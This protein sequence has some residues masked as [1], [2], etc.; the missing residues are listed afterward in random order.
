[1]LQFQDLRG[2]MSQSRIRSLVSLTVVASLAAYSGSR[3]ANLTAKGGS[4][5]V[6]AQM[7]S[8]NRAASL[9]AQ[10]PVV[11]EPN[12]GQTDP[13][14]TYLSRVG[15]TR[16]FLTR[17][18]AVFAVRNEPKQPASIVRMRTVNSGRALDEGAER[19]PGVSNYLIGRDSKKWVTDVPQYSR[20]HRKGVYQGIDMV[21]YGNQRQFE[22]DFVVAPGADAGQIAL[23]FD[24]VDSI[25]TNANGDLVLA[26]AQGDL[27]QKRPKVYQERN[28]VRSEVAASYKVGKGNQVQFALARYDRSQALVIDPVIVFNAE[29]GSS[30]NDRVYGIAVDTS[31]NTYVVGFAPS[32]DYPMVNAYQT[33]YSGTAKIVVS[34]LNAAGTALVYSTYI[35]GEQDDSGIGIAVDASGNALIAGI[36]DS[37]QFPTVSAAQGVYGGGLADGVLVKLNAAGSALLYST[38]LGGTGADQPQAVGVDASGNAYITGFTT[39]SFPTSAGAFQATFMGGSTDCTLSKYSSAGAR[40]YATYIGGSNNDACEAVAADSSGN[41]YVTGYTLSNDFPRTNGSAQ[42]TLQGSQD[43]FV[44]K[45]NPT[46]TAAVYST[47]FGGN[48]AEYG[49][50]IAIDSSGNAYIT[51]S[52]NSSD[53]PISAGTV[54][55][56]LGGFQNGF[57]AKLNAAG[58]GFL[59]V[60]YLGGRKAD[61]G[62]GIAVDSSNNIYVAGATLSD[63]FPT[64]NAVIAA[65]PG[66]GGAIMKSTD[67]GASFGV[68]DI[69]INAQL[70][71]AVMVNSSSGLVLTT[72][73]GTLYES[74]NL[75]GRW[76]SVPLGVPL[77]GLS[78]GRGTTSAVVYAFNTT[79]SSV[80]YSTDGGA[81]N[82]F[83]TNS[84][85]SFSISALAVSPTDAGVVMA[86]SGQGG[87]YLSTNN[88]ANWTQAAGGIAAIPM[89]AVAFVG[90][91]TNAVAC[92]SSAQGVY[93]T[94]SAGANWALSNAGIA[95][96][97]RC[98]R[99]TNDPNNSGILYITASDGLY[100]STNGG[101]TWTLLSS[102]AV[103]NPPV[104]VA[105]GNSN[106][107]YAAGPNGGLYTS[108]DGGTTWTV[109]GALT[110]P[111]INAL[112]VVPAS[113]GT[114][115]AATDITPES[116]GFVTELNAAGNSYVY[117]TFLG[118]P[119]GSRFQGAQA[120]AVDTSGNAYVASQTGSPA[121]KSTSGSLAAGYGG[122]DIAVTKIANTNPSCVLTFTTP[123]I[124]S[125]PAG[126]TY[127]IEVFA[128]SGCQW[129]ATP[130][131]SWVTIVGPTNATA[132]AATSIVV[133]ANGGVAR[134][135]TVSFSSGQSITINQNASTC[136]YAFTP[137]TGQVG[138]AGGSVTGGAQLNV[139]SG[140]SWAAVSSEPWV[141]ISNP[142]GTGAGTINLTAQANP[143]TSS[144]TATITVSGALFTL[145]QLSSSATISGQVTVQGVGAGG[146]SI[147][148]TGSQTASTTTNGSGNYSLTLLAGGSYTVSATLTGY[149]FSGPVT[150]SSLSANQTVNFTG[151]PNATNCLV[152]FTDASNLSCSAVYQSALAGNWVFSIGTPTTFY[153]AMTLVG[154]VPFGDAAGM[155][156]YNAGGG[157]GASV[158]LDLYNTNFN[159]GIPQAKI[160][161]V[162]D[163]AYSDH[164]TFWTKVPGAA[165]NPVTEK[166]RITSAGRVGIGT[167]NPALGPL[168]MG[169]GAYV[170]AGGVWTNASDRNVKENFLPVT[171]SDILERIGQVPILEWNYKGEDPGVR[172]IGPV[173]QDFYSIFG[174]GASSTSISTID[175]SGIALAGIQALDE[176]TRARNARLAELRKL[177]EA[178]DAELTAV[179]EQLVR[180]E[181]RLGNQSSKK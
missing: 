67:S 137:N 65:K 170:S 88:G 10:L 102:L 86:S 145:T 134:S 17:D 154:N 64:A 131:A 18:S 148:V 5:Q 159:G 118:G 85:A 34:K 9:L 41:A 156:L 98:T 158:S 71:T 103:A 56:A 121:F 111:A 146:V 115:F 135:T 176:S 162:D 75:G 119:A 89:V 94:A 113:P 152:A 27:I 49:R 78:A 46:G 73:N 29:M 92:S 105:T 116:V 181:S 139:A 168:Q 80:W 120:L 83:P 22:Y 127:P 28:G 79:P 180:L 109:S 7:E 63:N 108:S 55:P 155:A 74:D 44:T 66:I 112:A 144:R 50:G 68:S 16:L 24:G 171:A 143:Y 23:A 126:G 31:F 6:K 58:S 70:A 11:F 87:A 19:L 165:A 53:L 59:L 173:A 93:R 62:I 125:Y 132:G 42:G 100:K 40:V 77:V 36:T 141:T 97:S 32:A 101:I 8:H 157:A 133:A 39:G 61:S 95:A 20:L 175:P 110:T 138:A 38:Y 90:D 178:K 136:S 167:T 160:K 149:S 52:T 37:L 13:S 48:G 179:E 150:I 128:P 2:F 15:S 60:T 161:A 1:M 35:G 169:S 57:I 123:S 174:L 21:F 142:T 117:S 33:A 140:C 69:G 151:V 12:R 84:A 81:V 26:T 4:S 51:G 172:H 129:T 166:V 3:N 114:V 130:N 163:G 54:Q 106:I 96:G 177:L 76:I 43:A 107:L 47:L 104:A 99:I 147:N 30:G 164:L 25:R 124:V 14:V 82:W 45:L 72:A 153:G 122:W 91:S